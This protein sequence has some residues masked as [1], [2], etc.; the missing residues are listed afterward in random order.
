L[1]VENRYFTRVDL[2]TL[3]AGDEEDRVMQ[4]ILL[5]LRSRGDRTKKCP[6]GTPPRWKMSTNGYELL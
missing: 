5:H 3:Y 6:R 4:A 2:I 1:N